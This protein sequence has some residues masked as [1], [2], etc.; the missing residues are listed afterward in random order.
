MGSKNLREGWPLLTVQNM[1]F[2]YQRELFHNLCFQLAPGELAVVHGPN[3]KGKSTLLKLLV[4]LLRPRRGSISCSLPRTDWEYIPAEN[5]GLLPQLNAIENLK[6]WGQLKNHSFSA[7]ELL[8]ELQFWGFDHAFTREYLPVAKFSTGMKKKL[9]LSRLKLNQAKLWL[10]DE[11]FAG[12]DGMSQEKLVQRLQQHL[13][14]QG[15]AILVTHEPQRL[16]GINFQVIT[17]GQSSI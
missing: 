11:P 10:L 3:G 4:G 13:Q 5:C 1:G 2:G 16:T 7:P 9:A 17:V 8:A 15:L 12:L 14:Q 6:F